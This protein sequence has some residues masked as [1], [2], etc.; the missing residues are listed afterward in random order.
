MRA[1]WSMKF[2]GRWSAV[3]GFFVVVV[4]ASFVGSGVLL[5]ILWLKNT[6]MNGHALVASPSAASTARARSTV[7]MRGYQGRARGA[8]GATWAAARRNVAFLA[9]GSIGQK[10]E[11]R[12]V[13][14]EP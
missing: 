12:A 13:D 3:F 2:A 10:K 6:K 5:F 4:D 1:S 8:G 7:A 14:K 11:L 9:Q